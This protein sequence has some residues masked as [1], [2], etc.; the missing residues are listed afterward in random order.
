MVTYCESLRSRKYWYSVP[1]PSSFHWWEGIRALPWAKEPQA[2]SRKLLSLFI[3]SVKTMNIDSNAFRRVLWTQCLHA[4]N[5]P[6]KGRAS[7][8]GSSVSG[9]RVCHWFNTSHSCNGVVNST[10]QFLLLRTAQ[11]CLAPPGDTA[12]EKKILIV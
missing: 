10:E 3:G 1:Y 4:N 11:F 7:L 6:D 8:A 5:L 9:H 2:K 12:R